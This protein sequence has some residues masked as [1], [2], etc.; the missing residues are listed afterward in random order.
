MLFLLHLLVVSSKYVTEFIKE[1]NSSFFTPSSDSPTKHSH[2]LLSR[3]DEL[4]ENEDNLPSVH[5]EEIEKKSKFL[6][7]QKKGEKLP[8]KQQVIMGKVFE[9]LNIS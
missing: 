9:V 6:L 4:I 2:T 1:K 5:L 8:V 7:K 3:T